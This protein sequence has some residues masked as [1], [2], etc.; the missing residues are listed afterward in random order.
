MPHA[1]LCGM[2]KRS[3]VS[4][5]VLKKGQARRNVEVEH[6]LLTEKHTFLPHKVA[7][8][9]RRCG[10]NLTVCFPRVFDASKL[11]MYDESPGEGSYEISVNYDY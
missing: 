1:T 8:D 10:V 6:T 5:V 11:M 2:S 7:A 4:A 9:G 3:S